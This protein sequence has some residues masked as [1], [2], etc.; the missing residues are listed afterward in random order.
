MR[1]VLVGNHQA[2][3]GSL[4]PGHFHDGHRELGVLLLVEAQEV[5]VILLADLVTGQD[6]HILGIIPVDEGNILIDRVGRA[7]VPVGAGGLLV[8]RQHM[9]AAMQA[10]QVPR[11]AVADVLVQDQRLILGQDAH[12]INVGVDAVG[13]REVDDTILSAKRNC[14]L[15]EL[16]G[17]R[18][19][20][21]SLAAGQDH[22]DHF[23]CHKISP[24]KFLAYAISSRLWVCD[25][26]ITQEPL[27]PAVWLW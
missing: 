4:A 23:F 13:Q 20:A 22:C 14:R 17:Q 21:R 19:Q 7:L 9:D 26:S 5:G 27:R 3:A 6:D 25:L 11:L 12:R 16:L 10:V 8:G 24:L 15:G 1:V 18:I 2:E